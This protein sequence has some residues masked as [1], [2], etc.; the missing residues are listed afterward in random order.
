MEHGAVSLHGLRAGPTR[1]VGELK[2]EGL[3][4]MFLTN[5]RIGV[6]LGL[7]F[8]FL[9]LMIV[10]MICFGLFNTMKVNESVGEIAK[11]NYVKTVLAFQASRALDDLAGAMRMLV[12]LK[13]EKGIA[14]ERRKLEE[15]R[16]RYQDAMKRLEALERSEKGTRLIETAKGLIAPTVQVNNRVVE[17][18]LAGR[19]DEATELLL[20]EAVPL[21]ERVQGAFDEQLRFQQESVDAAYDRSVAIYGRTKSVQLIAGAVSVILG[22]LSAGFLIHNFVTRINRVAKAM[23]RVADGDLSTQLRIYANDEIGELGRSINRM[24]TSIAG[25]ITSIKETATG[26]ASAAGV[27]H[28]GSEEIATG[29]EQVAAQAG[30]VATAGEEMAATSSEIARNCCLAAASSRQASEL[31]TEGASV[32]QATVAGMGRI[33]ERVRE[34]ATA[35]KGLGSRSDQIGE[36]VGTI[37]DIADQTNLLALNAAI[38]AARAGEQGRGFAVVADEVRALAERTTRATKE[39]G[40]MIK[41]IQAETRDAV[42]SMEEGVGEVERGTCDAARSGDALQHILNQINDVTMQINQIATAAEQQTATTVEISSNIQQITAVAQ[43]SATGSHGSA[44]SAGELSAH[45]EELRSLV[46]RFTLAA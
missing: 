15:A 39:I 37:E 5:L 20:K 44:S 33:A 7:A 19:R 18:A 41:G 27:L 11:G 3:L 31:A 17:L 16:A 24:L 12:L 25:M 29:A 42:A 21:T 46:G 30:V 26:V 43:A 13:D 36:I 45:A 10:M 23:S 34:T 32:V 9:L 28:A 38:E 40:Q 6:K 1:S 8:G 22:L 35:V 2:G 4:R 14:G